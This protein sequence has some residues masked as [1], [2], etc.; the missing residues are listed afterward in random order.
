MLQ[1]YLQ[2]YNETRTHLSLDK[3]APIPRAVEVVGCIL[4][5]PVNVRD[6]VIS[7]RQQKTGATLSIP[8]HPVLQAVLDATPSAH[9]TFLTTH[10]G[11]PF[12][13][14]GFGNLFRDWCN[15]ADV[16]KGLAHAGCARHVA[17]GSLSGLLERQIAA[18]GHLTLSEIARYTRAAD[19]AKLARAAMAT[20]TDREQTSGKP[21]GSGG[22]PGAKL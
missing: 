20:I 6:G 19:Q 12:S 15:Q 18:I 10:N 11:E 21:G 7:L 22:K 1:S 5:R 4:S 2:Y 3:D 17:D 14:A 16:Q 13:P 8:V 9:L